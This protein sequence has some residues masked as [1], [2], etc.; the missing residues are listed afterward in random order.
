[1]KTLTP[2]DQSGCCVHPHGTMLSTTRVFCDGRPV[3]Y[4]MPLYPVTQSPGGSFETGA[5]LRRRDNFNIYF[6]SD[7]SRFQI[8]AANIVIWR[9]ILALYTVLCMFL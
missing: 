8:A 6:Y 1:V 9:E 5:V 3:F 2:S 4:R 7:V